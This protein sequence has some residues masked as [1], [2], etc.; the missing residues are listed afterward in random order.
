MSCQLTFCD[1]LVFRPVHG[2]GNLKSRL[3]GVGRERRGINGDNC[4]DFSRSPQLY[5]PAIA[6]ALRA[7]ESPECSTPQ[8]MPSCAI[9]L[10]LGI[11]E[12]HPH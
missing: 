5:L 9:N 7:A 4:Q 11:T 3:H 12:F 1:P 8:V 2:T 6:K 10:G